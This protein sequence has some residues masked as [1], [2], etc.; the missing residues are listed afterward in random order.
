MRI[1]ASRAEPE[2][3]RRG[4]DDE[5]SL[6]GPDRAENRRSDADEDERRAPYG[7]ERDQSDNAAQVVRMPA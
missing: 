7:S 4:T 6:G 2:Q 5:P 1:D 3:Q